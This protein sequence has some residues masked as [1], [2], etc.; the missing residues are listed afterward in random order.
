MSHFGNK[1]PCLELLCGESNSVR[2]M[3][4]GAVTINRLTNNQLLK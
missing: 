4:D 2:E 3:G 1:L